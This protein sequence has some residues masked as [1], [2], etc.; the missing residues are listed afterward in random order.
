MTRS[1]SRIV[2]IAVQLKVN[3]SEPSMLFSQ[4]ISLVFSAINTERDSDYVNI[5]DGISASARLLD[6]LSGT[7]TSLIYTSSQ[8]Y[9]FVT[10]TSDS[11]VTFSGFS[12]KYSSIVLPG[13]T[14]LH[15]VQ[16]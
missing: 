6:S 2:Q 14:Q 8:H 9:M 12:A 15:Y 10:F 13:G 11:S 5:Y 1:A 7:R 3:F 16:V 4:V